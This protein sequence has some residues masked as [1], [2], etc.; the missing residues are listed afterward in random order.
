[1]FFLLQ[2]IS[3]GQDHR[4]MWE[5]Q[6]WTSMPGYGHHPGDGHQAHHGAPKVSSAH[7]SL[8]YQP[9]S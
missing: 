8:P 9:A 7:W 3:N 6:S 5:G 1:M 2:M 4:K